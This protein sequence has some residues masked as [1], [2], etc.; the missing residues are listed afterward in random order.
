MNHQIQ[1]LTKTASRGVYG[2]RRRIPAEVRY[3]WD[4]VTEKVVSFKTTDI[5]EALKRRDEEDRLF[6]AKIATHKALGESGKD[7]PQEKVRKVVR[8][9]SSQNLLPQSMP[10]INALSSEKAIDEFIAEREF[11]YQR[12]YAEALE[13]KLREEA[14]EAYDKKHGI[15]FEYPEE[16]YS[17]IAV[18]Y[19]K[20]TVADGVYAEIQKVEIAKEILL[21]VMHDEYYDPASGE[22]REQPEDD[23]NLIALKI[24]SGEKDVTPKPSLVNAL[25]NYLTH[26]IEKKKRNPR[27]RA[28]ARDEIKRLVTRL[29]NE[30]PTKSKTHLEDL[31]ADVLRPFL[32][33]AWPTPSTRAKKCGLYT[34]L[35]NTWNSYHPKEVVPN[36]F[37]ALKQEA[38]ELIA[39]TQKERR[40]F[41]PEEFKLFQDNLK[42]LTEPQARTIGL[43]MCY[44]G[45][46]NNEIEGLERN[47][48]K[49]NT[50][51]PYI[52][53]RNNRHR[54]MGKGRSDRI[55]PLVGRINQHL[56]SYIE[57][58]WDGGDLLFPRLENVS[59]G[60]QALSDALSSCVENLRPE[61][62]VILSPYSVRDTFTARYEAAGIEQRFGEYLMG[63]KS[64][65]QSTT[66][67]KYYKQ[68]KAVAELAPIMRRITMVQSWGW[69][70][71]FD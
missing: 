58:H 22:Y 40:A 33:R 6:E 53:I 25:D 41:T 19:P 47:D 16:I 49:L 34:S 38:A 44:C 23:A 1:F 10:S 12:Q 64:P 62:D 54:I 29:S 26:N 28:Q 2:Y 8:W 5:T 69:V 20:Q 45:A 71:E 57:N 46:Q 61:E 70:E 24:L 63:H 32:E 68:P 18:D 37:P 43:L 7:L 17:H 31:D 11:H 30:F 13:Y 9:L 4:G 39:D 21:D 66:H 14:E 50:K 52:F 65:Q 56:R 51:W 60:A 55:I 36:A 3:L 59:W 48:V 42:N 67:E 27:T 35:I 15:Q